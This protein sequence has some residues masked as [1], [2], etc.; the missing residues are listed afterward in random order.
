MAKRRHKGK[1]EH[2]YRPAENTKEQCQNCSQFVFRKMAS[3]SGPVLGYRCLVMGVEPS[4]YYRIKP[5]HVC[6]LFPEMNKPPVDEK[7][8]SRLIHTSVDDC[9]T[10]LNYESDLDVLDAVLIKAV[11]LGHK[12]RAKVVAARIKKLQK[13]SQ[14]DNE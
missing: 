12:T 9:R 7:R 5:N 14:L 1:A 3:V 6:D 13:E 4:V 8:V 11:E 2:G 10:S